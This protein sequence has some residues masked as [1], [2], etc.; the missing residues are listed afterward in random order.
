MYMYTTTAPLVYKMFYE[1]RY[2]STAYLHFYLQVSMRQWMSLRD[3]WVVQTLGSGRWH[4]G[5]R[6]NL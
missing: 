4:L 1:A 6:E 2:T 5:H 3:R